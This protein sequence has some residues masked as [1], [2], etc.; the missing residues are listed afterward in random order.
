MLTK[1]WI[2]LFISMV[3]ET[4]Q[5]LFNF[6]MKNRDFKCPEILSNGDVTTLSIRC[7]LANLMSLLT[8]PVNTSVLIPQ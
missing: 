7:F 3:N 4:T 1:L 2:G 8:V 5:V 6:F